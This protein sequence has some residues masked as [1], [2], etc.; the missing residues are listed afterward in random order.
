MPCARASADFLRDRLAVKESPV[1]AGV[2]GGQGP[3][4]HR[5]FLPNCAEVIEDGGAAGSSVLAVALVTFVRR[6]N[7]KKAARLRLLIADEIVA[8]PMWA[9]VEGRKPN[10]APVRPP[11]QDHQPPLNP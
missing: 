9:Q 3:D 5:P 2:A 6:N 8:P 10:L 7:P 1:T 4:R 11:V